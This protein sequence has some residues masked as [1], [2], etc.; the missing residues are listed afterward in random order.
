ML[1]RVWKLV[2]LTFNRFSKDGSTFQ[3]SYKD[4]LLIYKAHDRAWRTRRARVITS[5]NMLN[6]FNRLKLNSWLRRPPSQLKANSMFPSSCLVK[7]HG[8]ILDP[9][10]SF[11]FQLQFFRKCSWLYF[12]EIFYLLIHFKKIYNWLLDQF[13][14][15][16]IKTLVR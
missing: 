7:N 15:S 6:M 4:F 2:M 8:A 5:L 12:A 16:W 14:D 11:T 1:Q 10:L 9:F 3:C 13:S